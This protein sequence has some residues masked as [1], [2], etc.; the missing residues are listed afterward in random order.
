MSVYIDTAA[1][2]FENAN[3]LRDYPFADG[4][5]LVDDDGKSLSKNVIVDLHLTIPSETS[6]GSHKIRLAS[7]H[8]S[9]SMVSACFVSEMSGTI[10]AMSVTVAATNFK[11]Y[12][13]YRLEKLSGTENMGG[14]VTFGEIDL[15]D[16]PETYRFGRDNGNAD[17]H[18]CCVLFCKPSG[19]RAFIDPKSGARLSGDVKIDFSGFINAS[20]SGKV[21]KLEL[22]EGA[23]SQLMSKCEGLQEGQDVCGATPIR[24]INGVRPDEDGNIV[25]WFH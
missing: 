2:Q 3:A 15:P 7:V 21:F 9:K 18:S 14:I 16:H 19:L 11:P 23:S 12:M 17:I 5:S 10:D 4:C 8:L 6:S 25:L 13:P 24:S 22:S 20:E 1:V